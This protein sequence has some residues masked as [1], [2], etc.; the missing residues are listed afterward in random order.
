MRTACWLAAALLA[1]CSA[2]SGIDGDWGGKDCGLVTKISFRKDGNA[3]L[4]MFTGMEMP[5]T[6]R[7][8]GDKV[9]VNFAKA[10]M[11]FTRHGDVLTATMGTEHMRCTKL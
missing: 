1:A 2:S 6:Y 10:G 9:A 8:D 3:Y 4:T 7:V 5:A 11:V